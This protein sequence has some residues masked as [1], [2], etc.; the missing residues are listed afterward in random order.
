MHHAYVKKL[1]SNSFRIG[2]LH[3]DTATA[4]WRAIIEN[5]HR[6]QFLCGGTSIGNV[7]QVLLARHVIPVPVVINLVSDDDDSLIDTAS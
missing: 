3:G 6:N 5:V 7:G 4:L 1:Y 2:S